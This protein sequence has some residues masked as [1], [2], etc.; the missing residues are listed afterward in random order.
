VMGRNPSVFKG[1]SLPVENVSW[2]DAVAFC[3]RMSELPAERA[4]GRT[5][6]LP[7]EAEWEYACQAGTTT[8]YWF[9]DAPTRMHE[10][11]WYH[12]NSENKTHPVGQK[13]PNPWGLY[14][15][16][17]NV[18]EW[19]ADRSEYEIA[20]DP[21]KGG[22]R[23]NAGLTR[24]YESG[25]VTDPSGPPSGSVRVLRGGNWYNGPW[26]CRSASR[27]A[28]EPTYKCDMVGLRVALTPSG[29]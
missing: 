27:K 4:A 17:G 25:A 21:S 10:C 15:M 1:N 18:C 9:G 13:Q 28:F 14:D 6:R 23:A 2:D 8:I 5:Y 24:G 19:C 26:W 22:S 12:E 7:T 3:E 20:S 29:T 16:Y 11:G